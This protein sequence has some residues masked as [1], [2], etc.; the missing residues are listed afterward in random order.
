MA[1]SP[2]DILQKQFGPAR[3]QGYEPEEVQKFLD[4]VRE[5]W[6]ATL[7]EVDAL[8]RELHASQSEGDRLRL[9]QDEIRETL[10]LARRISQDLE[11]SARRE[12]DI[13]VGEAR[14]DAERILSAAHDEERDLQETVIRLRASKIHLLSELRSL[15]G[16][17]GRMLDDWE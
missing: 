3:R 7:E 1:L 4:G 9:Q 17:Q 16:A 14:L 15:I 6:E 12:S 11:G 10:I 13:I 5:A 8:R 2:L